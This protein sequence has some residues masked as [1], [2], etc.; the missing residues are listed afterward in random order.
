MMKKRN[1]IIICLYLFVS[2][3]FFTACDT[4]SND[5]GACVRSSPLGCADGFTKGEC[6]IINGTFY[7]GKSCDDLGFNSM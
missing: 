5:K 2:M 7:K 4:D 6:D 1:I 3:V